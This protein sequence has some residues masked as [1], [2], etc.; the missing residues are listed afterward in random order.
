VLGVVV[1]LAAQYLYDS[2]F[3]SMPTLEDRK[4]IRESGMEST[5]ARI[6]IEIDGVIIGEDRGVLWA[7]G[8]RLLFNGHR[9]SFALGG[10]LFIRHKAGE[11]RRIRWFSAIRDKG[12]FRL[13]AGYASYRMR[14]VCLGDLRFRKS[15][16]TLLLRVCREVNTQKRN[17]IAKCQLP[18]N[19]IDPTFRDQRIYRTAVGFVVLAVGSSMMTATAILSAEHGRSDFLTCVFNIFIPV[20]FW[21]FTI[22]EFRALAG[23]VYG[24]VI[25]GK[26]RS[27]GR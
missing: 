2:Y 20:S 26:L 3:D 8:G 7:E 5:L 16:E 14:I 13:D 27:R 24:V 6:E 1:A 12:I 23:R 9:T 18:P 19:S 11:P 10:E 4:L 22:S 25:R 17:E 15:K 21:C